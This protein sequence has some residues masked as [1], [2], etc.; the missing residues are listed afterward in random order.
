[1][2]FKKTK[3]EN[4]YFKCPQCGLVKKFVGEPDEKLLVQC[5]NCGQN[6]FILVKKKK[7]D[8]FLVISK[9]IG[10]ILIIIGIY[11]LLIKTPVIEKLGITLTIIGILII[12]LITEKAVSEAAKDFYITIGLIMLIFLFFFITG[13]SNLEIFF[14]IIFIIF[15]VIKEITEEFTSVLFKQRMGIFFLVSFLIFLAIVVK[16]II[17]II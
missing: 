11:F 14:V 3:K 10:V 13:K 2:V 7:R 12:F 9:I 1:M 15:V 6:G 16:R 17:S 8:N 4:N 5:P